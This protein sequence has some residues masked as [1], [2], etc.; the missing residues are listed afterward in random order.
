MD[1]GSEAARGQTEQTAAGTDVQEGQ[2]I[3][4]VGV[5]HLP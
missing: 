4:S 2:A 3:E 1:R 5:E